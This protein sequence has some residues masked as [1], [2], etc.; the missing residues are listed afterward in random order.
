VKY[1]SV[2]IETTGADPNYCDIIEFAAVADDL[3]NPL[4]LEQLKTFQTYLLKERYTGEP[5]ALAIHAHI[6]HKIAHWH[7]N[8]I[9]IT[10]QE[11]LMDNFY[12][13]LTTQLDYKPDKFGRIHVNGA[14]K[15]FSSFDFRFLEKLPNSH[16]VKFRHRVLD[17]AI[18]YLC[19]EDE[20]LQSTKVCMQ[21]AGFDWN[22][23]AKII[24]KP[25]NECE[26]T[27]LGD[28]FAV[29]ELIRRKFK[30]G[31]NGGIK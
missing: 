24:N 27:A 22:L 16:L 10:K 26:H 4:P 8:E 5:Y 28:A 30:D 9:N 15:N 11:A 21:R 25:A 23:I 20:E 3:K 7:E 14:G 2:D 29:V 13:F 18:L 6:F 31:R 1:L 17:P 19:P 12:T